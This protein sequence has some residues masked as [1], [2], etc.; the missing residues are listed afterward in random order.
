MCGNPAGVCKVR[1][2]K[3]ADFQKSAPD[4]FLA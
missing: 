4:L 3:G 1:K 2:R